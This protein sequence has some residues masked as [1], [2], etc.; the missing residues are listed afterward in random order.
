MTIQD[1]TKIVRIIDPSTNHPSPL[2]SGERSKVRGNYKL[3][4]FFLN[5]LC[6]SFNII[7]DLVIT[8]P[9]YLDSKFRQIFCPYLIFLFSTFL[10]MLATIRFN[11]KLTLRRIKVYYVLAYRKL[12]SKFDIMELTISQ[13]IPESLFSVCLASS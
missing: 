11:A 10:I 8:E 9:Q 4:D 1:Q 3:F 7:Q 6:D 5:D 13:E 2:P 12:P